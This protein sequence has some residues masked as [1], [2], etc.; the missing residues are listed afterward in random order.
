M[1]QQLYPVMRRTSFQAR[2]SILLV[3]IEVVG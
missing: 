1:R 2:M 3:R